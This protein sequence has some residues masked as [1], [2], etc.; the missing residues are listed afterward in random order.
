MSEDITVTMNRIPAAILTWD[1]WHICHADFPF[2]FFNIFIAYWD[3][4]WL[5]NNAKS[6]M[7]FILESPSL[8]QKAYLV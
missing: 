6:N 8:I 4:L 5:I 7:A 3:R 1:T 2:T